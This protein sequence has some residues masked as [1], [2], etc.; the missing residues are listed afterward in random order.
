MSTLHAADRNN[1]SEDD[2]EER[3]LF[4]SYVLGFVLALAL[5]VVAFA[6]VHW[7]TLSR[8]WLLGAVG[9]LALLQMLV[10]FKFFLHLGGRETREDLQL[11][12]FS[13][14]L[15]IIMVTGTIWIMGSLAVRMGVPT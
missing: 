6:L 7:S 14:L 10:H 4:R 5:T 13:A 1:R 8:V 9:V 15:L 12:V 11:I 2:R 3:T